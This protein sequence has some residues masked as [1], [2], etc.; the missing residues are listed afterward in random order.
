MNYDA[1]EIAEGFS[2]TGARIPAKPT[3]RDR[4]F[5]LEPLVDREVFA[6]T[7][8]YRLRG[9]TPDPLDHGAAPGRGADILWE[10]RAFKV[11][12]NF[13]PE[14]SARAYAEL[15]RAALELPGVTL[16]EGANGTLRAH[17]NKIVMYRTCKS[18]GQ[19]YVRW[20]YVG[21]RRQWG[22]NC[23]ADCA[24]DAKRR[25]DRERMRAKRAAQ[26]VEST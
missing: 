17:G 19:D 6:R 25:A 10:G 26:K 22:I 21:Q 5:G 7:P 12:S 2:V 14:E 8:G 18:C 9:T 4:K 11:V 16:H 15:L 13:T 1:D 20:R 24:E 3:A 23:S